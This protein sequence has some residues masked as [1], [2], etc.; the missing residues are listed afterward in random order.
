MVC[1]DTT[2]NYFLIKTLHLQRRK[3]GCK[4]KID[5][6]VKEFQFFLAK[7]TTLCTL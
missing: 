3:D 2:R 4:K 1:M 7:R 6:K 5:K